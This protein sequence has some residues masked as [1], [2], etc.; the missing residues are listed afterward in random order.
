VKL[1]QPVHF[2]INSEQ[3]DNNPSNNFDFI[4]SAFAAIGHR[5]DAVKMGKDHDYA[6]LL[7]IE[8]TPEPQPERPK[9]PDKTPE[10]Q[11]KEVQNKVK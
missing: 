4:R 2:I 8:L 7:I 3:V 9:A 5:A 11:L 6:T 1:F 10:Q